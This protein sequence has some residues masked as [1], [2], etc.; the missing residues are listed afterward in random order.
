MIGAL[1]F[2][3]IKNI[4]WVSVIT[5]ENTVKFSLKTNIITRDHVRSQSYHLGQTLF[6]GWWHAVT[7]FIYFTLIEQTY[8]FN[9]YYS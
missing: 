7:L 2:D 3:S 5:H 9:I 1:Y 8:I 6:K 4:F